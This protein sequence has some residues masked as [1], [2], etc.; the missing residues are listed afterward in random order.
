MLEKLLREQLKNIVFLELKKDTL[1]GNV[2]VSMDTPLPLNLNSLIT[3]IKDKEFDES[4]D[5]K[6]INEAIVYLLGIDPDFKYSD[7]Y[8]EILSS[9]V[10]NTKNY[11]MYL[12]NISA[13]NLRLV[14]AYIYLNSADL[15]LEYDKDIEFA[16]TNVLE[17][18][19]ND[20]FSNMSEEESTEIIKIIIDK[21][22]EIL[23]YDEKYA[24]AYYRLAY[25]NR[26]LE[27]FIKSK[28]YF[29]KFLTYQ[30]GS[31][32]LKEEVREDLKELEDYAIIESVETYMSY[33]KFEESYTLLQKVSSLYPKQDLLYYLFS[34]CQYNLNLLEESLESINVALSMQKDIEEYYNQKSI[35]LIALSREEAAIEN[36]KESFFYIKES[37]VL[38]YN[39]GILLYN[40]GKDESIKYLKK[41]YQLNPSNE[42]LSLINS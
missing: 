29:E 3:G 36:Y 32:E 34:L 25:I 10:E 41:A 28:L 8:V 27:N 33:G 20:N 42:I 40:L 14:D 1:V 18:I 7:K 38:N 13:K 6:S 23:K 31:E 16:K 30:E 2:E 4:I 21:Y 37:Y 26:S 5:L 24:L 35:I 15:L 11:I 19:Y 12:S 39:L 22:E 9:S 17:S